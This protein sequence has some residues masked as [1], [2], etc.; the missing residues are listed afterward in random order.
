M[1]APLRQHRPDLR[2]QVFGAPWRFEAFQALRVIER[3]LFAA[4]HPTSDCR[5]WPVRMKSST[6]MGFAASDIEAIDIVIDGASLEEG[7]CGPDVAADPRTRVHLVQPAAGLLGVAGTLSASYTESIGAMDT[8]RHR[9][10]AKALLDMASH[11]AVAAWYRAWKYRL[12][13]LHSETHTQGGLLDILRAVAG[14]GLESQ[15]HILASAGVSDR[16]I[17]MSAAA[18]RASSMTPAWLAR[19]L[20]AQYGC[21]VSV[22]GFVGVWRNIPEACQSRI[23]GSRSTLDVDL[24]LGSMQWRCDRVEL[25]LGPLSFSEWQRFLPDGD[26]ARSLAAWIQVLLRDEFEVEVI[27]I[28]RASEVPAMVFGEAWRLGVDSFLADSGPPRDRDDARY[29]LNPIHEGKP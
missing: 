29:I 6:S 11:R 25:R 5:T 3:W 23:G 8:L 14:F 27:P 12:P 16:A 26:H 4:G 20:T 7:A 24:V 19:V 22:K 2:E 1:P 13:A 17:A 28:L 9:P 21:E 18:L 15:R 10:F